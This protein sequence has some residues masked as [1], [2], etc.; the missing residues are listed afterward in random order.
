MSSL[1]PG[2]QRTKRIP[3][4]ARHPLASNPVEFARV[5]VEKLE[6]VKLEQELQEREARNLMAHSEVCIARL[7]RKLP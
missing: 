3:K 5:L 1:L 7:L 2:F 6:K 4:E